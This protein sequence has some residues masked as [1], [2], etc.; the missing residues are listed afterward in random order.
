MLTRRH[1]I[2]LTTAAGAATVLPRGH[3][4][5]LS[6][7]QAVL[8]ATNIKIATVP[9]DFTGLSY[10]IVQLYNPDFFSASN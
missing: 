8:R 4:Q 5:T 9:D 7:G 1:F 2:S 6:P 3:A 10:E